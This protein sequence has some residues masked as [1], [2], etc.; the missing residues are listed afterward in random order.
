MSP[1]AHANGL[2]YRGRGDHVESWFLKAT[3]PEAQRAIWL[4]ATV[5]ASARDP[6][7]ARA[8]GWAVAFD[9]RAAEPRHTAVKETVPYDHASFHPERLDIRWAVAGGDGF[10]MAEAHAGADREVCSAGALA[11]DGRRIA[12]EIA[13][14]G[15]AR[16]FELMPYAWMYGAP[17]PASKTFTP[18]PDARAEG[19]VEVDGERWAVD[20]W[21]AMQGHNWQ[22]AHGEYTWLHCNAFDDGELAV[23]A[24]TV[25]LK[26]GPLRTPHITSVA[27]RHRGKDYRFVVPRSL[28]GA[29][30]TVELGHYAF[31]AEGRAGRISGW[32]EA[33][34]H[35][36]VGLGYENPR[37][38]AVTCLNSKLATARVRLEPARG[39]AVEARSRAAALEFGTLRSDHGVTVHV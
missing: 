12:W 19:W 3:D 10:R 1:P 39:A 33:P 24:L 17:L 13:L 27:A 2:H 26:V 8:E 35:D 16:A 20:G 29:H 14:R 4:K 22:R 37:G 9:R 23:E 7:A 25:R 30:A 34:A 15:P 6:A 32:I 38:P 5:L 21:R 36:M 28:W 18:L 31:V 11:S